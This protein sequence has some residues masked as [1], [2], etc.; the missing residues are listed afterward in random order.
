[1]KKIVKEEILNILKSVGIR[2]VSFKKD[3]SIKAMS[4]FYY[5]NQGIQPDNLVTLV[6]QSYPNA[7]IITKGSN[8]VPFK[9]GVPVAKGSHHYVIFKISTN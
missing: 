9:G 3:G 8:F 5:R 7:E 6:K 1:M 2:H 4:G